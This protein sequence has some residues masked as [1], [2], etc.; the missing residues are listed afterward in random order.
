MKK[1]CTAIRHL[2]FEDLGTFAQPLRDADYDIQYLEA[3]T[4]DL[5]P[6]LNADL[7]VLLG[8][9]VG[10]YD[11][12]LYPFLTTELAI[13]RHRLTEQLPLLG[14]CLGAQII[15][16]AAGANV[17]PGAAG[18]EIGWSS[19]QMTEPALTAGFA[20]SIGP[21]ESV[22]I[23]M[24]H[25]HGDT[26]DLPVDAELLATTDKYRQIFRIGSTTL[27]FQCHPEL[28]ADCIEKWLL[29]HA[30]EL[31]VAQ[32]DLEKIRQDTRLHGETLRQFSQQWLALWLSHIH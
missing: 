16:A 15:A 21:N 2:H 22:K 3:A 18:K 6:A 31:S 19:L 17:Y 5:S 12:N 23:P 11:A 26:F 13:A 32:V 28:D 10:V 9:P 29:G 1:I 8:G 4:D 7:C 30:S 25:W 14:V 20:Q 24:F 27:A